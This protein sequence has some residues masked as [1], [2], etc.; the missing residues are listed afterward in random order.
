MNQIGALSGEY[1]AA[2]DRGD[3]EAL[4][5][6]L[7][8][9]PVGCL[10]DRAGAPRVESPGGFEVTE[11]VR[12]AIASRRDS[13][14][15]IPSPEALLGT[16]G[17]DRAELDEMLARVNTLGRFGN[18]ARPV[19]GGPES[20]RAF[21][22]L[23]DSAERYIH[24]STYILGGRAGL[25]LAETL[26][27]KM[28]QG[29][30]VR[31]LFCATGFVISGS[32]SGTGFVSRFSSLRSYLLNDM[33][34][35]KRIIRAFESSGVPYIN[36]APLAR[37]WRRRV[38]R[39][40]GVKNADDYY[41]WARAR[42]IPDAWLE[43]Q[44]ALDRDCGPNFANVDHRKMV[45]VDGES[46]FVGSQNIADS[47][48]YPNELSDDARVNVRAW[49]WHD[50]STIL[51]GPCV[52]DLGRLFA[53]RWTLSGGDVFDVK[54]AYY[55]P[56]LRRAGHA[57]VTIET[58]VP[59][60]MKVPFKRNFTRL[61]KTLLG[62]D[63][64]PITEGKNPIR[65]RVMQLPRLA[66]D[67]FYAEHCYPSDTPLLERWIESANGVVDFTMVVPFHYDTKVL[68]MECDRI[69]PEML[70]GGVR[71]FGYNRA[72][73]HS[74]IAVADGFYTSVGSYN[75]TLRS[76]RADMELQF[77]I[78]C[79]EYGGA[80]RDRIRGD[81]ADCCPVRPGQ[82][83]RFRQRYSIPIFDGVVRYL[84]L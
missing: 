54:D 66:R 11:A 6:Y 61:M 64:R 41:R 14:G 82:V 74:K 78:Q 42:G 9:P 27:R 69:Y 55:S 81:L 77:F 68:G 75:L 71:L 26:A 51:E 21:F 34:V 76:G 4:L 32:P 53:E 30:A 13:D 84:I 24:V 40:Q 60:M 70:A 17:L 83:A 79:S 62:A 20:E 31:V 52:R 72:I 28:A 65:E 1:L 73:L 49:Q 5:A 12:R 44:A 3:V 10:A 59:G 25:R 43:S 19:W 63:V 29:V 18:R 48:F 36:S 7:N 23:L 37:H 35:R 58:S 57:V 67:D 46:A 56:P 38:L 2:L 80:V 15:R 50:N 16:P 8:L 39:Q 47:Y 22:D 33:Y 45:I